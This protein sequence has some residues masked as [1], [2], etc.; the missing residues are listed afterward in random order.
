V[1]RALGRDF[2]ELAVMVD[3]FNPLSL[4]EAGSAADD[5]S[6]ARSWSSQRLKT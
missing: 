4:G 1:P 3:T 6:Y 5:G 2:F